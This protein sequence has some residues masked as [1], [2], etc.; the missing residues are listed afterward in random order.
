MQLGRIDVE[1]GIYYPLIDLPSGGD[2]SY[3]GFL[4]YK[5]KLW[6]VYYSSHDGGTNLYLA[7]L[8]IQP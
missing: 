2:C 1:G 8:L 7:E 6:V 5:E 4:I 3:P